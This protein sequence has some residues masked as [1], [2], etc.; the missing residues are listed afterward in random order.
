MDQ[1]R[2]RYSLAWRRSL[3]RRWCAADLAGLCTRPSIQRVGRHPA[4]AYAWSRAVSMVSSA[5]PAIWGCSSARWDGRLAF[6]SGVGVLLTALLLP[7]LVARIRAE[8][9]LL[10]AHFGREYEAYCSR[11]SR[12]IPGLY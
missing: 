3:R 4:R 10:R 2:G 1:R 11:T 6:R 9:T 12:L 7:P 8:E 5:T